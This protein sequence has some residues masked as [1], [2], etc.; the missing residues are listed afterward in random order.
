[1]K[2]YRHRTVHPGGGG[3]GS[4]GGKGNGGGPGVGGGTPGTGRVPV[5]PIKNENPR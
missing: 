5:G 4:G 3:G 1:M 2:K